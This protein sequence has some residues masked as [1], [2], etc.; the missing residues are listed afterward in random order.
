MYCL[1]VFEMSEGFELECSKMESQLRWCMLSL[2][3]ASSCN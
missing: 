2:D 3:L 1:R